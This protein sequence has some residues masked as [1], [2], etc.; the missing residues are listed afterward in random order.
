MVSPTIC[1]EIR[2]FVQK[3]VTSLRKVSFTDEIGPQPHTQLGPGAVNRDI[4]LSICYCVHNLHHCIGNNSC[5]VRIHFFDLQ[6]NI[7]C[8]NRMNDEFNKD[9]AKAFFLK[10]NRKPTKLMFSRDSGINKRLLHSPSSPFIL[11]IKTNSNDNI[12]KINYGQLSS[13]TEKYFF[14][15]KLK[16]TAKYHT[17]SK[18]NTHTRARTHTHKQQCLCIDDYINSNVCFLICYK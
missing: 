14:K 2:L 1:P 12:Y 13:E 7:Q 17:R 6:F 5:N 8:F 3:P 15:P 10:K 4:R 9:I 11:R 16:N 18:T